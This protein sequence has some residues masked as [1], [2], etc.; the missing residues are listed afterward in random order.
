M[1]EAECVWLK[2][3]LVTGEMVRE[4]VQRGSQLT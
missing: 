1:L 4:Q 3:G 2:G